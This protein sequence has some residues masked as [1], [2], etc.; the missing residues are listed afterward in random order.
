MNRLFVTCL[1]LKR[2]SRE[3]GILPEVDLRA[4]AIGEAE[5]VL[6]ALREAHEHV[7]A[8]V[9]H[10]HY[11]HQAEAQARRDALEHAPAPLRAARRAS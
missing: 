2:N 8:E 10:G 11:V 4:V 3:L 1:Y 6:A 5:E 9:R 7:V